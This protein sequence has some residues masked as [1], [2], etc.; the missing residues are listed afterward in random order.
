MPKDHL[1]SMSRETF[2][3]LPTG[4]KL[5]I[6]FDFLVGIKSDNKDRCVRCDE[7]LSQCSKE[8]QLIRKNMVEP[9]EVREIVEK[10]SKDE[11]FKMS[12]RYNQKSVKDKI[13][14]FIVIL[15]GS[16]MGG[17]LAHWLGIETLD[18]LKRLP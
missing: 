4:N 2:E 1:E 9:N 5:D 7:R 14:Y 12:L 16:A 11:L 18:P 15:F 17:M 8:F 13:L 6:L 3:G 10:V